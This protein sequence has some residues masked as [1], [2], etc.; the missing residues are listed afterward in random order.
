[1]LVR[2]ASRSEGRAM[3]MDD[4]LKI[5]KPFPFICSLNCARKIQSLSKRSLNFFLL[6][7]RTIRH[8]NKWP[9]SQ[10]KVAPVT[11]EKKWY[12][13]EIYSRGISLLRIKTGWQ[14]RRVKFLLTPIVNRCCLQSD[15]LILLSRIFSVV[16]FSRE[17]LVSVAGYAYQ[18]FYLQFFTHPLRCAR[19][20]RIKNVHICGLLVFVFSTQRVW[21]KRHRR[22]LSAYTLNRLIEEDRSCS[23]LNFNDYPIYPIDF[24]PIEN[25]F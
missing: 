1:M 7:A 20:V 5:A 13:L 4:F 23:S 3:I 25:V 22:R 14:S 17:F 6:F 8:S 19:Q 15:I 18:A 24:C 11:F 2:R 12:T 10:F 21:N 9:S 16:N